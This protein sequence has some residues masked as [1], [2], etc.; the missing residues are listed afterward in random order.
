[1]FQRCHATL[2]SQMNRACQCHDQLR[3]AEAVSSTPQRP[4][5]GCRHIGA[6]RRQPLH[7]SHSNFAFPSLGKP[8]EFKS[9]DY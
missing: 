3:M 7:V 5:Q 8:T 2:A 6:F 9:V 4:A 1:M